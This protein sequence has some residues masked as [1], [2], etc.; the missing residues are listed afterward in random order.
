MIDVDSKK[1]RISQW[2]SGNNP[3]WAVP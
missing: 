1:K 2:D 3:P